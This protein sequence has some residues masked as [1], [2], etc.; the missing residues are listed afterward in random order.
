MQF[1]YL[2]GQEH[3]HELGVVLH[4]LVGVQA[5]KLPLCV[6]LHQHRGG[7]QRLRRRRRWYVVDGWR[8]WYWK[9]PFFTTAARPRSTILAEETAQTVEIDFEKNA[10]QQI[11]PSAVPIQEETKSTG[12]HVC[13]V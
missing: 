2:L 8:G 12:K 3:V 11:Q 10:Q 6:R 4:L 5:E 1:M 13:L 7:V 9:R